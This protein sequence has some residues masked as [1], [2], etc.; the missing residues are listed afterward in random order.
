MKAKMSEMMGKVK[1]AITAS[2][3]KEKWSPEADQLHQERQG[4]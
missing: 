4:R 2:C 3:Q 1:G